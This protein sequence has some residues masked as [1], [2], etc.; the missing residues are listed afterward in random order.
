MTPEEYYGAVKN[1]GLTPSKNVPT[2]YLDSDGMT[3]GVRSPYD[4]TAEQ[5][6]EFIAMLKWKLGVG[7]KPDVS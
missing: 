6:A 1:L 3:Y 4:L 5:R 7:P 2:V